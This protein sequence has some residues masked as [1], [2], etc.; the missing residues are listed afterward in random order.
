MEIRYIKRE[1][2]NTWNNVHEN[3]KVYRRVSICITEKNPTLMYDYFCRI[4]ALG[5]CTHQQ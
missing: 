2:S 4:S 1:I 3:K 5:S